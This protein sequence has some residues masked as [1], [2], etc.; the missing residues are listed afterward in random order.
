MYSEDLR[1]RVLAHYFS[2]TQTYAG[3]AKFFQVSASIVR[4]WALGHVP[5]GKRRSKVVEALPFVAAL[6]ERRPFA[7]Y[8]DIQQEVLAELGMRLS[9]GSIATIMKKAGVS[10][11]RVAVRK[12]CSSPAVVQAKRAAFK[13]ATAPSYGY[14]RKG[15]RLLVQCEARGNT[16]YSCLMAIGREGVLAARLCKGAI[17]GQ[18]Y[19]DF[20]ASLP[21]EGRAVLM[22]NVAF[23]RT[24]YVRELL[25]RRGSSSLFTPPLHARVQPDRARLLASEEQLSA[26]WGAPGRGAEGG[27]Y[28][29]RHPQRAGGALQAIL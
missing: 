29:P 3:T 21:L 17:N 27:R 24:R 18:L 4:L 11:K 23:H 19:H 2:N 28:W 5:T 9:H 13:M 7:T 10:R 22:D 14:S 8:D 26:C 15:E 20:L 6:L 16:S 25:E 12:V 1:V